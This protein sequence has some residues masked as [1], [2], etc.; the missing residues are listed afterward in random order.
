[1]FTGLKWKLAPPGAGFQRQQLHL[2]KSSIVVYHH[3]TKVERVARCGGT[4][5]D[6][7]VVTPNS[8]PAA[9]RE[10]DKGAPAGV[11]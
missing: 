3:K 6:A 10:N 8:G 9:L 5:L 7:L 1:V 4:E 11:R 2:L